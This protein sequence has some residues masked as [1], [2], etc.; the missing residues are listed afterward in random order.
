LVVRRSSD[1]VVLLGDALGF[2]ENRREIAVSHG[3]D[4]GRNA[5]PALGGR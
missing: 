4:G 2:L 1:L 5:P 3:F